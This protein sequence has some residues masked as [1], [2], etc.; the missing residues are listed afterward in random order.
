MTEIILASDETNQFDQ[1][2]HID[3][4]DSEYW[5]ATQLLTLLGYKTWKRIKDTVERAKI[6]IKNSGNY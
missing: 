3:T 1:I 5:L 6:S 2:K 4:D